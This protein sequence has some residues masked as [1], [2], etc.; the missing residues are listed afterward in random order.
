MHRMLDP[1]F[2]RRAAPAAGLV[3]QMAIASIV[4]LFGGARLDEWLGT[5][6]WLMMLGVMA[7][8][9]IG[10]FMLIRGLNRMQSDNDPDSSN[11]P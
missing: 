9:G 10:T 1:D 6:P 3:T 4:G 8:F 7:G 11:P 5:T 2:F